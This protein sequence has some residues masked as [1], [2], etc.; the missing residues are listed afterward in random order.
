MNIRPQTS[1]FQIFG[2]FLFHLQL[3]SPIIWV[4]RNAVTKEKQLTRR[5]QMA[6]SCPWDL[7]NLLSFLVRPRAGVCLVNYEP[8]TT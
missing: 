4:G 1:N 5:T 8:Q 3:E 7:V 2:P 6:S